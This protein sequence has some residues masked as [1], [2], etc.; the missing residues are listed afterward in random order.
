MA[1]IIDPSEESPF[2]S[3]GTTRTSKYIKF[4]DG[5]IWHITEEDFPGTMLSSTRASL[6]QLA[7][8]HGL[9]V[10]TSLSEKGL[11]VQAYEE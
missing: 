5:Q 4:L 1:E 8:R 3:T 10:R 6:I 9:R 11:Y 2:R 7:K